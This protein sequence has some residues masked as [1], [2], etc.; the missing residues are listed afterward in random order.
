VRLRRLL[1]EARDRG[2]H[3]HI[4]TESVDSLDAVLELVLELLAEPDL[5]EGPSAG[6]VL[7]AYLRESP[8]RLRDVL[9]WAQATPR[10]QPLTVRLVKGAY[11]DHE[12]VEAR[13]HGWGVPV[14]EDKAESDRNFE[15]LSRALI[16]AKPLVRTAIASHNLRS[17]AHA[18]AYN[19]LTG[20]D[21]GDI[22]LQVLR[23]L[24]DDLQDALAHAGFRVRA[25]CPV[26]ELVAG[27]AYL[28]RRLLEN[29]ANES[30]LSDLQ[31]GTP[32][33]ELLAAP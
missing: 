33:E 7:Q 15:A 12:V 19:R 27:M 11:W 5:A 31:R 23:G 24:G 3:L 8:D 17:V 13:Q 18:I 25:Y 14:F 4:D 16:D 1:V 30:F 6:I 26:G 9:A 32:I 20:G 28:V 22:E 21:D 29:T 2:A 10:A